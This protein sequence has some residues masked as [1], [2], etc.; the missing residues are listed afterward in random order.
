MATPFVAGVAA[1]YKQEF[2][3][4]SNGEIRNLM[5]KSAKD[6]G[7]RGKDIYY[8]YGLIQSPSISR[9]FPDVMDHTWYTEEIKYLYKNRIVKGYPDGNFHLLDSV[10]RAEAVTMLGRALKLSGEQSNTVFLDVPFETL[11]FRLC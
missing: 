1:L 9:I 4:F 2:P 8:G 5:Q 10:T 11:R 3:L 7:E 6:L